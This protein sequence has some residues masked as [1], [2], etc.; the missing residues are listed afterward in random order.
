MT[1]P[2]FVPRSYALSPKDFGASSQIR[3]RHVDQLGSGDSINLRVAQIHH[4]LALRIRNAVAASSRT[5]MELA[6]GMGMNHLRLGRLLRGEIVL[7]FEDV[8]LIDDA[9]GTTML[10]EIADV[11]GGSS[12]RPAHDAVL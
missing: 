11:L 7:R 3:W 1:A 12:R 4:V 10:A 8:A 2:R 9:L 6:D 5:V